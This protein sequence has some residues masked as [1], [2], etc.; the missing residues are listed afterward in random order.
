[1]MLRSKLWDTWRKRT[2]R[3]S[4]TLTGKKITIEPGAAYFV[5]ALE[6]LGAR[7]EYSCEGHPKGFY[8]SFRGPYKLAIKV[9][10]AGFFTVELLRNG[11][12]K[13][14]LGGNEQSIE[15][16]GAIFSRKIRNDILRMATEAWQRELFAQ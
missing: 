10:A 13:I 7:T 11:R 15:G 12:W 2:V 5:E 4:D 9:A 1:M 6:R 16:G 14:S 3:R 8:V